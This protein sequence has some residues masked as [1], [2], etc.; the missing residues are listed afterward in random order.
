MSVG[1]RLMLPA[2]RYRQARNKTFH[3]TG[4]GRL[5]DRTAIDCRLYMSV[6]H[7]GVHIH[8]NSDTS[9]TV[10]TRGHS[11]EGGVAVVQGL[12][13]ILQWVDLLWV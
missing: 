9:I 3:H 2:D 4:T 13:S 7:A 12:V 8:P 11:D 1:T 5:S 6:V 10:L